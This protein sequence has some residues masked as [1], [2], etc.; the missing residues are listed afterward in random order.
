MCA[1]VIIGTARLTAHHIEFKKEISE[2]EN[3]DLRLKSPFIS[4]KKELLL[5]K[6]KIVDNEVLSVGA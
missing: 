4:E 1:M 6:Y 2:I 5:K 3:L